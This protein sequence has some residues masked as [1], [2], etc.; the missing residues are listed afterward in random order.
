[1]L[2]KIFTSLALFL[3]AFPLP[4]I[5]LP[6][7]HHITDQLV[8]DTDHKVKLIN[9]AEIYLKRV[10]VVTNPKERVQ[11]WLDTY[12]TWA[13]S[14][15]RTNDWEERERL[16]QQIQEIGRHFPNKNEW[17]ILK[18]LLETEE[19]KHTGKKTDSL[20]FILT[21]LQGDE[22]A[23]IQLL[24]ETTSAKQASEKSRSKGITGALIDISTSSSY[25]GGQN[26]SPIYEIAVKESSM[27]QLQRKAYAEIIHH[28]EQNPNRYYSQLP[29]LTQLYEGEA[30]DAEINRL[31]EALEDKLRPHRLPPKMIAPVYTYIRANDLVPNEGFL[32][33]LDEKSPTYSEDLAYYD[34]KRGGLPATDK[35]F[36]IRISK[37]LESG[38]LEEAW[39]QW[40]AFAAADAKQAGNF[41][42]SIFGYQ[43]RNYPRETLQAIAVRLLEVGESAELLK[44]L[45]NAMPLDAGEDDPLL[46]RIR[47]LKVSTEGTP[48]EIAYRKIELERLLSLGLHEK[49][50]HAAQAILAE[51]ERLLAHL[52]LTN[53]THL[54]INYARAMDIIEKPRLAEA[55]IELQLQVLETLEDYQRQSLINS[56][57]EYYSDKGDDA[58]AFDYLESALEGVTPGALKQ[59]NIDINQTLAELVGLYAKNEQY[60]DVVHLLD[61]AIGWGA[62]DIKDASF[63]SSNRIFEVDAAVSLHAVGR[64]QQAKSI[65]RDYLRYKDNSADSAYQAL[66]DIEGAAAAGFFKKLASEAPFEERPLIWQAVLLKDAGELEAAEIMAR[67]AISIDPT[68]GEMNANNRLR[69]YAVLADILEARDSDEAAVFK[70]VVAAVDLSEVADE[71]RT[72]GLHLDALRLYKESLSLFA[73]AYCV[74]FRAAVELE[75][76]GL[77]AEA[78]EHFEAAYT[79][80]PDQFGRIESHCFGCEGAFEGER[81][82]SIAERVFTRMLEERPEQASLHYL[83]GYLNNSRNR[84]MD[85]LRN[86]KRAVEIDPLYYNAWMH[87]RNLANTSGDHKLSLVAT[88][89]MLKIAPSRSLGS[90]GNLTISQIGQIWNTLDAILPIMPERSTE[91]YP[92]AASAELMEEGNGRSY[93]SWHRR[94]TDFQTPGSL[95]FSNYEVTQFILE[96]L[97]KP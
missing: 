68:D 75:A 30:L 27:P 29:D 89:A 69:A 55:V 90:L 48:E 24:P 93:N 43:S 64:S 58:A 97:N 41:I 60:K 54:L 34:E 51:P 42:K 20:N 13:R 38:N 70:N 40:E 88:Q 11:L 36:R 15:S 49:A 12:E 57:A 21:L 33:Y 50:A 95:F 22:K 59:G 8:S 86:F 73:D 10:Q 82:E 56:L 77:H 2:Q 74:R 47:K 71:Y 79:L 96:S 63:Y 92:L 18:K 28:I 32:D 83:M 53:E 5:Q 4:A 62:K 61:H 78:E 31:V 6:E 66:V 3:S 25:M 84:P 45:Q 65:L 76:A 87:L 52:K 46:A 37:A 81:A 26:L 91:I 16:S 72:A 80:M 44:I 94:N 7:A 35:T 19:S 1:M 14:V 39:T 9:P 17:P 23:A 67:Q 85:A